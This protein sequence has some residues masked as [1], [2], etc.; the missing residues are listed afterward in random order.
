MSTPEKDAE[1]I[2]E[3]ILTAWRGKL[4]NSLLT[5]TYRAYIQGLAQMTRYAGLPFE[6]PPMREAIEY[7]Q[8]RAA[9]LVKQIDDDTRTQLANV[10]ADGIKN[11][12]GIPGLTQDIQKVMKDMSGV[13]SEL[14]ARTETNTALSDGSFSRMK[15]IG[16][17]GKSWLTVGDD[18]VRPEHVANEKAGIIPIDQPFPD[19]SMHPPGTNPFN[20]RCVMVPQMLPEK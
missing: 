1:A 17:N 10:I 6:G 11:K 20:C 19:G 4:Y 3:P 7:A 8:K 15:G 9:I 18:K 14:I 5:H 16:V 12:R 2:I 13:R